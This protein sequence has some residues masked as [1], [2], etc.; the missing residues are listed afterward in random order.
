[1]EDCTSV[2]T[3]SF[4][5]IGERRMSYVDWGGV[6]PSVLLLHGIINCAYAW[7]QLAPQLAL[8]GYRVYSLD[9][10]GHGAS[11]LPADH[12]I[13]SIAAQVSAAI[14][15]L[16]LRD[17]TLIGHSWGGAT[18]LALASGDHPARARLARLALID[19]AMAMSPQYGAQLLPGYL[20][21]LG[22]PAEIGAANS[23]AANPHW[24]VCDAYWRGVALAECRA[25]AVEGLFIG[26]GEWDLTK[27]VGA[28]GVPLLVL[29]ADGDKTVVPPAF[30]AR[31]RA[32]LEGRGQ[33]LRVAGTDHNMFYGA[34]CGPTLGALLGWLA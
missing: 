1:M 22:Q 21:R 25:A 10:P 29:I 2:P 28:V 5:Q 32:L 26:S 9:L 16:D 14:E 31:M 23:R 8:A 34:G 20:E 27:R 15:A 18:A 30:Q 7:W 19:P 6:G 4:A 11:D 24:H 33:L 3:R 12:H 13:D 17:L